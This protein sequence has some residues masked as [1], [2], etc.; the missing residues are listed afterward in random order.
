MSTV[1]EIKATIPKLRL[2][3]REELARWVRCPYWG[4]VV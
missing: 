4:C 3:E 1:A 2:G